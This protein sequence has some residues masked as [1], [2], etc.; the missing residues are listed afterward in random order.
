MT[1]ARRLQ[2]YLS[3]IRYGNAHNEDFAREHADFFKAMTAYCGNWRG[4]RALDVGCGKSFWLTL[5]LHSAGAEATG[6]DAEVT[7]P[8]IHFRKYLGIARRNGVERALRTLFWDYR[9][10][11]PYYRTLARH[12]PFALQFVGIDVR[13]MDATALDFPDDTFDVVV[14]H[15]VFEH[16]PDVSATLKSLARVL[17]PEGRTYIY[18]HNYTSLS[19]GHHIAWKYPDVE[20]SNIVPPWDHLRANLHADIPSWINRKREH[21]YRPMFEKYF[22]IL[23]WFPLGKEGRALLTPALRKELVQYSEDELLT[24]GFVVVAK[25]KKTS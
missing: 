6:I 23:D 15:E 13:P 22:D 18:I 19:G 1:F 24:K 17:K 21:E 20:P 8:H 9:Y 3:M 7:D 16:L 14:S 2:L 5:L 10:A 11:R 4:K 12:V 25:P